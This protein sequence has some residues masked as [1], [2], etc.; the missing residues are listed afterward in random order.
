MSVSGAGRF[1][2]GQRVVLAMPISVRRAYR[3][4]RATVQQGPDHHD[5]YV[6]HLDG[7]P[8]RRSAVYQEELRAITDADVG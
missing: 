2:I 4:A 6:I 3:G 7:P 5:I 1:Q 8:L